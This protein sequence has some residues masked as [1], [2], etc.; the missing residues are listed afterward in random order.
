MKD[1]MKTIEL[2]LQVTKKELKIPVN[3]FIINT[4]TEKFNNASE[5]AMLDIA[6][7]I[8][9]LNESL[10]SNISPLDTFMEICRQFR[11]YYQNLEIKA[12]LFSSRKINDNIDVITSWIKDYKSMSVNKLNS[13]TYNDATAYSNYLL[14]KYFKIQIF[15]TNEINKRTEEISMLLN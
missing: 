4:S 8:I 11:L 14:N 9:Y 15:D 3:D 12:L 7:K 5:T 1:Y 10:L 6:R 13:S 2:A